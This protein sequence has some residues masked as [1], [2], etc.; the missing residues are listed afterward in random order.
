MRDL[1]FPGLCL[2]RLL[3]SGMC[4]RVFYYKRIE[5]SNKYFD[6]I[7]RIEAAASISRVHYTLYSDDGGSILL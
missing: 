3:K 4:S 5:V 7:I 6:S 2:R 1:R